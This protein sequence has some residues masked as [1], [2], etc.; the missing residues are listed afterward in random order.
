MKKA[1]IN[2]FFRRNIE[3]LSEM[4]KDRYSS[5][6]LKSKL[7]SNI[8]KYRK[9][10]LLDLKSKASTKAAAIGSYINIELVLNFRNKLK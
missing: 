7:I 1:A 8:K 10:V 3:V 9:N 5:Q 6:K 4:K 2:M